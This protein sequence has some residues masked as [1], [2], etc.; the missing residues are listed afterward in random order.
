M[1]RLILTTLTFLSLAITAIAKPTVTIAKQEATIDFL[2]DSQIATTY[3]FAGK[4]LAKP[5]F[6][7][8]SAPGPISVTRDWPMR[9]T[10]AKDETTDHVHQKSIWFCHGDVIPEGL[11]YTK[12]GDKHVQGVDFWSEGKPHGRI[13]CTHVGEPKQVSD[14]HVSIETQNDWRTPD[15]TTILQEKRTIHFQQLPKGNLITLDIELKATDY[16]ITFGDT[17]EGAMGTRVADSMTAKNGGTLVNANGKKGESNCWGKE[18]KWCDYFKNEAGLA[19]F[20]DPKNKY[21]S[22]WHIRGYGLMAAN[23]FGRAKSGFPDRK[24]QTELV[25]L[26]KGETLNLRYGI[27]AHVGDTKT[28]DV[29]STYGMFAK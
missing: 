22:A 5:Y 1:L 28:G 3:H 21:P 6:Y 9:P 14:D 29:A 27:Y 2:V 20:D 4:E 16:P 8:M 26:A 7:P 25:K 13:V 19:V 12:A 10:D 18:A 15:G 11:D 24:E 17:K 23:P